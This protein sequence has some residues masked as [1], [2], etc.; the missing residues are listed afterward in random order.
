MTSLPARVGK[1][2]VSEVLGRGSMG[3]V[4]KGFDPH[5]ARTVA[6][7]TIHKNLLGDADAHAAI[8]ARFRN[9]AQAV[10]RL[11]HPGIVAIYEYGEDEAT[12]YIAMEFVDGQD[13]AQ[14]LKQAP[15]P[16]LPDVLHLMAQLLDALGCAHQHGVWHRDLKPANLLLARDGRLKLGDFGIARIENQG[17]T[18]VSSMIGSPGHMAPEQYVGTGIDQ[19]TDLYAAGVLLY[20]LLTGVQPFVGS[21]ETLMYKTLHE[22]PQAP[23]LLRPGVLSPAHDAVLMKAL[24]KAPA[25]RFQSAQEMAQAVAAWAALPAAFDP[26]STVIVPMPRASAPSHP[27]G[28]TGLTAITSPPSQWNSVGVSRIE[29][30]L[31]PL[32]GPM[33]RVFMRQALRSAPDAPSLI[34][35]VSQH[36]DEAQRHAFVQE[37]LASSQASPLLAPPVAAATAASTGTRA[38]AASP[39]SHSGTALGGANPRSESEIKAATEAEQ[40]RALAVMT[41]QMGPMA[42]VVIKRATQQARDHGHWLELLLAASADVDQAALRQALARIAS[43]PL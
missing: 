33:A 16:P 42:R 14:V 26:D 1:Y 18:Q 17:L 6:I 24:A 22:A 30:L 40:A 5:I 7:K 38:A 43:K 39:G 23:S 3:V 13:L 15:L 19:R 41:Q 28:A 12:A 20:R 4:Y 10:G 21:A 11:Q 27:A 2:T 25:E 37:A 8:A 31:A 34:H 32:V 9:E 35:A 36:V 29:K